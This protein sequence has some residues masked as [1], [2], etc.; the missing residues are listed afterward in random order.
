MTHEQKVKFRHALDPIRELVRGRD[1]SWPGA[2]HSALLMDDGEV[3]DVQAA[4][5]H[6]RLI[7]RALRDKYLHG[8]AARCGWLPWA[9]FVHWEGDAIECAH[10]GR[11]IESVYGPTE[12]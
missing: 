11:P 9:V 12:N 5:K 10:S 1:F 6:Y 4:R 2:N 8:S 3:I 7:V